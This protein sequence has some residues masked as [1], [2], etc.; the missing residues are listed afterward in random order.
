MGTT[1][2]ER[3]STRHGERSRQDLVAFDAHSGDRSV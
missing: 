2:A 1:G 3:Y